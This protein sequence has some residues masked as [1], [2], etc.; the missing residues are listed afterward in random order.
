MP[1]NQRAFAFEGS[2]EDYI[3]FLETQ[4]SAA[5]KPSSAPAFPFPSSASVLGKDLKFLYFDPSANC[6][7]GQPGVD[8]TV[9]PKLP[10]SQRICAGASQGLKELRSFIAEVGNIGSWDKRRKDIGLLSSDTNRF[11]VQALRGQATPSNMCENDGLRGYPTIFPPSKKELIRRGC[12]YGALAHERE[13]YGDLILHL[14]KYQQLVFVSL[15]TVMISDG[16]PKD[17]VNW[18]M[19]RYVSD[20]TPENLKRLRLGSLWV[21]RCIADLLERG[22]GFRSWEIFLLCLF[23]LRRRFEILII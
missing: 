12:E 18:M 2:D 3:A 14:A 19:R 13:I 11:A 17:V 20:T 23:P 22:W 6:D 16:T 8:D 10:P 9:V 21:N 5:L 1:Q 4:L 7:R 15:C